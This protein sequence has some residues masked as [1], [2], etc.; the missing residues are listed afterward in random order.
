MLN[1]K[2]GFSSE[3]WPAD[4]TLCSTVEEEEVKKFGI[5]LTQKMIP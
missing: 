5:V 2:T 1:T 3:D 4:R